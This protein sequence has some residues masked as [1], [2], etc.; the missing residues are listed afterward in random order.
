MTCGTAV[1]LSLYQ[2]LLKYTAISSDIAGSAI[3]ALKRHLWY[4][5]PEMVTLAIFSDGTPKPEMQ[6]FV[7]KLLAVKPPDDLKLPQDLYGTGFGKS[8]F[9]DA[10][11]ERT[12]LGN[13]VTGDSWFIVQLLEM[14]MDLLND[15]IEK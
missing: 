15:D 8:K 1:D 6:Y 5:C 14:D 3:K 4:L 9:L 13:S 2:N 11:I 12:R 10:I 7:E